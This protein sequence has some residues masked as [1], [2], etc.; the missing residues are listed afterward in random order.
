MHLQKIKDPADFLE[1]LKEDTSLL[2]QF[3]QSQPSCT[4]GPVE[5]EDY[6]EF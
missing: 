1:L 2:E 5:P 3:A 6:A 4:R